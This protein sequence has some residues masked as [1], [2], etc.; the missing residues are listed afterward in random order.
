MSDVD[1]TPRPST[2]H[3]SVNLIDINSNVDRDSPDDFARSSPEDGS[4]MSRSSSKASSIEGKPPK[5]RRPTNFGERTSSIHKRTNSHIPNLKLNPA[6]LIVTNKSNSNAPSPPISATISPKP[7][8]SP[9]LE[10]TQEDHAN[11][12]NPSLTVAPKP[13]LELTEKPY[14]P[15]PLPTRPQAEV[16]K[17]PATQMYWHQPPV[18][19]ML[20]TA[21]M[22]RSHSIAQIGATVYFFG[23]SDGGPPKATNTVFIFDTGILLLV[24]QLTTRHLILEN[25][26]SWGDFT[27][28]IT[29]AYDHPSSTEN[30]SLWWR[31]R[32]QR[33]L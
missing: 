6:V 28:S 29:S 26:N 13:D 2:T 5:P 1:R 9:V 12:P 17:A 7:N 3:P 18:H 30:I 25:P 22:R 8:L 31:D 23:G 14:F 32:K 4:T 33:L 16:A 10:R 19:G 11:P 15:L 27:A 20:P 21:P 24:S